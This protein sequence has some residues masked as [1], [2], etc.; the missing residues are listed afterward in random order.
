MTDTQDYNTIK[1]KINSLDL[2]GFRGDGLI[3]D[4]ISILENFLVGNGDFSHVG[5]ALKGECL[6]SLNLDPNKIYL[7]EST[8]LNFSLNGDTGTTAT[9]DVPSGENKLGVQLRELET[10][11]KEYLTRG[12]CRVAWCPLT[13]NPLNRRAEETMTEYAKRKGEIIKKIEK[14]YNKYKDS[15]YEFNPISLMSAMFSCCRKY[16][17][18]IESATTEDMQFCS[19]LVA[20]MYIECGIISPD[21]D[22]RDVL[23]V[24]FFGCDKDGIPQVCNKPIYLS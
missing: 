8:I 19:E 3:S 16:R 24:D 15:K 6:P 13:H 4:A 2:I 1:N 20:R 17:N 18:A 7:F 9:R 14:V 11:Y 12:E 22:A 10:A 21:K 5:V 23:P